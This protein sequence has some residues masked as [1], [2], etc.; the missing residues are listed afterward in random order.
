MKRIIYISKLS[1]NISQQEIQKIADISSRNNEKKHITGVLL[2]LGGLFFQVIE[3]EIEQVESLYHKILVDN[4]HMDML[5]LK[6]E[7]DVKERLYPNWA[8][9]TMNL[10]EVTD[11]FFQPIKTL[12]QTVTESHRI[13]EKYTQPSI[14]NI[15]TQGR[16]PLHVAP[17]VTEKIIFFSDICSFSMFAEK[18]PV[19]EIVQLV[20]QYLEICSKYIAAFGGEVNKFIGD[21]VM[22]SFPSEM[23]DAA[24]ECCLSILLALQQLREQT[25]ETMPAHVLYTGIGLSCGKV[26]EGNMGSSVKMDYTLLGD[27]VNTAARLESLTRDLPYALVLSKTVKIRANK[28]WP[29]IDL[30]R[31]QIKGKQ[32][33]V[34]LFSLE[35]A[36]VSKTVDTPQL[37]QLI[38]DTLERYSRTAI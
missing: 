5:C 30:G 26:I 7:Y 15:L 31:H 3:G 11:I 25:S 32:K 19:I 9:K 38:N 28:N 34:N 6:A 27:E 21:S 35:Q 12:L 1:P 24:I 23:A 13:L 8:M 37:V 36:V 10:D 22:A 14:I 16:N 17:H 29:F 20:N 18:L 4:R 33:S 2:H